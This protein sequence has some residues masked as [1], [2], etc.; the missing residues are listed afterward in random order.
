[1]TIYLGVDPGLTGAIA[2]LCSRRGMLD[3]ADLPTC[4]NGQVTG[5]MKRWTD[6]D[7][8]R[9][10]LGDWREQHD[11]RGEDMQFFI[12]RPIAMPS[13]PAQTVASQ[14]DTFGVLRACFKGA[15][16]VNPADW[17][18]FYRITKD[19]AA[20][21]ELARTLYP[22]AQPLLKRAKDHNRA[23]AALIAHYAKVQND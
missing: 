4:G 15:T 16:M 14:F 13:L 19:K 20:S 1:M 7:A 12:E 11:L 22:E 3:I 2:L 8:L 18:R 21:L 23:E 6:P 10:Q 5:H 17:K 9:T